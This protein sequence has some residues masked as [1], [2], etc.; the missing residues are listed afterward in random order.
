MTTFRVV[1]ELVA[2]CIQT[3]T[4]RKGDEE[5]VPSSTF[6]LCK[7]SQPTSEVLVIVSLRET[8]RQRWIQIKDACMSPTMFH[9]CSL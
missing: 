8:R 4:G 1:A 6:G 2:R 5:E 9:V 7:L 3:L